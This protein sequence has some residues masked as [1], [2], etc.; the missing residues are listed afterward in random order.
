[1]GT[2]I[3]KYSQVFVRRLINNFNSKFYHSRFRKNF[4][5][6]LEEDAVQTP[7]PPNY[8][9]AQAPPSSLPPRRFCAV[10]GFV[11]C[12]SCPTCGARYCSLKC[13]ETHRETR[14]LKY[15]AWPDFVHLLHK[16]DLVSFHL[17]SLSFVIINRM[18]SNQHNFFVLRSKPNPGQ[19]SLAIRI[20]DWWSFIPISV[21]NLWIQ[22]IV[23]WWNKDRS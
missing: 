2:H 12:Q 11:S 5:Q 20:F 14:C 17:S 6:L 1:M 23:T 19:V 8:L 21:N 22:N 18:T 16:L 9:S 3:D 10:C 4:G 7:D 13:Q 15:T